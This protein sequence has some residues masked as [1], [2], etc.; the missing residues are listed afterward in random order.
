MFKFFF[1]YLQLILSTSA[2]L[3]YRWFINTFLCF[4]NIKTYS[5][6]GANSPYLIPRIRNPR[7][8]YSTYSILH[9]TPV[10]KWYINIVNL[11]L[12]CII[13]EWNTLHIY[14]CV[15]IWF[16][17][18]TDTKQALCMHYVIC[19]QHWYMTNLLW[20]QFLNSDM[21]TKKLYKNMWR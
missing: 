16:L 15:S 18:L 6:V 4:Q 13:A 7:N 3:V 21:S 11:W 5:F 8:K 12:S 1:G 14:I 9:H 2:L 10:L 17:L 20:L 19:T